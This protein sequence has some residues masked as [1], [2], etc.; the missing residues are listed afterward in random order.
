MIGKVLVKFASRWR[1]DCNR[2]IMTKT[3]TN[4]TKKSFL[5]K[6][7]RLVPLKKKG[8]VLCGW[9]VIR[10]SV[11]NIHLK[12]CADWYPYPHL[13]LVTILKL[14]IWTWTSVCMVYMQLILLPHILLCCVPKINTLMIKLVSDGLA[15]S[16]TFL[17]LISVVVSR[18]L[19]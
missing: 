18:N 5:T 3:T 16:V 9:C 10:F 13:H 15:V 19:T 17:L 11:Y 7:R 12:L 4:C 6:L 2:Q 14:V 1:K 8:G